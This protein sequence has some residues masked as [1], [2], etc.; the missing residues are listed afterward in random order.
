MT[1]N[2]TSNTSVYVAL[3]EV[4]PVEGCQLDPSEIA[5]AAVRCYVP[6]TDEEN[7]KREIAEALEK[8]HFQVV[9]IQWCV[10]ESETEW[11]NPDDPTAEGLVNEA[12]MT[13]AVVYGEFH[14][15]GPETP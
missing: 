15:W 12:T 5:G 10:N 7:A 4:L 8:D 9:E 3:V 13:G 6:S 11:E 14:V 2:P 1:T